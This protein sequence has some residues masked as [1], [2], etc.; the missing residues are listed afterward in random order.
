MRTVSRIMLHERI[1]NEVTQCGE[2]IRSHNGGDIYQA[3]YP[4][5]GLTT[6][7]HAENCET[8]MCKM[9]KRVVPQ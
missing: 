3:L 2:R 5:E 1:E 4:H 6:S 8:G 9:Y 7:C